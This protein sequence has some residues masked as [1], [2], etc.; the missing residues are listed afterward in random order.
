VKQRPSPPKRPLLV[1]N[2]VLRVPFVGLVQ[3]S[4][5]VPSTTSA[6]TTLFLKEIM[7]R[8]TMLDL[9]P[10]ATTTNNNNNNNNSNNNN[11]MMLE[12]EPHSVP[13]P[14]STLSPTVT[15]PDEVAMLYPATPPRH[16]ILADEGTPIAGSTNERNKRGSFRNGF[17]GPHDDHHNHVQNHHHHYA[18]PHEDLAGL[19]VQTTS[20]MDNNDLLPRPSA[21]GSDTLHQPVNNNNNSS[22]SNRSNDCI[23]MQSMMLDL[24]R[25]LDKT[26][27]GFQHETRREFDKGMFFCQTD[28]N[29]FLISYTQKI[30]SF[31]T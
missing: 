15:V 22:S 19:V 2:T 28:C 24:K 8:T 5:F 16:S 20:S 7:T 21:L 17:G 26:L 1:G 25:H 27:L 6:R 3:G 30:V 11:N 10:V 18:P 23:V 9:P 29:E 31:Q 4:S 12:V 14:S 13:E